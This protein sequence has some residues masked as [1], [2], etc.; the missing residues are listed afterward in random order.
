MDPGPPALPGGFVDPYV[1]PMKRLVI[2]GGG[3]GGTIMAN[4]LRSEYAEEALSITVVD[5]DDHHVYQPGLLFVDRKS[6][7]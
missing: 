5:Q 2:L 7:V 1:G 6:V 4:R 3:T